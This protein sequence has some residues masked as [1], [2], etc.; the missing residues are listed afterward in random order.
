MSLENEVLNKLADKLVAFAE[1]LMQSSNIDPAIISRAAIAM[2][3][4]LFLRYGEDD[5]RAAANYLRTF[6]AELDEAADAEP[7]ATVN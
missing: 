5:Q 3:V 2:S 4:T 1:R 6:A 7:P